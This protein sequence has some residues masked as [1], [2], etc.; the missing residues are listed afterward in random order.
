MLFSRRHS[1]FHF[2]SKL[3]LDLIFNYIKPERDFEQRIKIYP[4]LDLRISC[5]QSTCVSTS[6]IEYKRLRPCQKA[7]WFT[8]TFL[9]VYWLITNI[10]LIFHQHILQE[11]LYKGKIN[12]AK[13][14]H[15]FS[16]WRLGM[17]IFRFKIICIIFNTSMSKM[18]KIFVIMEFFAQFN[19]CR[20]FVIQL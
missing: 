13:W 2:C 15:Y 20:I 16:C 10:E 4:W 6:F 1:P 11:C 7:T 12:D 19:D 5:F 3:F 17:K 18:V 14:D 9:S 8:S